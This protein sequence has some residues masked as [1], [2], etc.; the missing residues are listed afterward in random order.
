MKQNSKQKG[1]TFGSIL[2]IILFLGTLVV[3]GLMYKLYQELTK[4]PEATARRYQEQQVEIMLPN[5]K[6]GDAPIYRNSNPL[7][8]EPQ[9]APVLLEKQQDKMVQEKVASSVPGLTDIDRAK[10]LDK[11]SNTHDTHQVESNKTISQQLPPSNSHR[12]D[13]E[14]PLIPINVPIDDTSNQ[15]IKPNRPNKQQ[16]GDS[17]GE[18]F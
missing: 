16:S 3:C 5:A 11:T 4:T 15:H 8:R 18:L 17:I 12:I 6:K 2:L 10:S 7:G 9:I 14:V 13:D 1:L